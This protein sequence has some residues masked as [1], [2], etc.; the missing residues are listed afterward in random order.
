MKLS[1]G[2]NVFNLFDIRNI[3]NVYPET[4]DP[5][6]RSAY[7]TDDIKLTQNGGKKSMSYYD[8]P[9]HY[10][11]PREINVFVRIDYK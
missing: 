3:N 9:W 11:T 10:S 7:F 1:L 4:G 2:I 6:V 5:D 8:T